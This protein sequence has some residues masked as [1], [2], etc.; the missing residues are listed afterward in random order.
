MGYPVEVVELVEVVEVL[1]FGVGS[2]WCVVVR[3]RW[4]LY[5]TV[6]L[7]ALSPHPPQAA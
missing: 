1:Q 3:G 6:Y 7:L 2:V 5:S 4:C